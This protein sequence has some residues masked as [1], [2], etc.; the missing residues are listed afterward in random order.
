MNALQAGFASS[1]GNNYEASQMDRF[2]W[3]LATAEQELIRDCVVDRN[4]YRIVGIS[5]LSTWLFATLA[6]TYFFATATDSPFVFTGMG[7]FMGFVILSIDR[8]LIKGI[9]RANK[10]KLTPL[11]F[12][13]LLAIT[14]GTFMAQPA[15]LYLFDKEI[16]LQTSLDNEGRKMMKRKELD[17]LY[18]GQIASVV[19]QQ[20]ML[21]K[22]LND[23]YAEVNAARAGFLAETDGSG[24]SGKVGI[25][26][27]ALAKKKE[28]EKLESDYG[29]LKVVNQP[30]IDSLRGELRAIEDTIRK[31]QAA[32]TQLL[33]NGFLTRIQALQNL[34]K[35]NSALATRYWLVVIILMLI[36]L[37]PVIAKTLLPAGTYD[38]KVRLQEELEKE[39][40]KRNIHRDRELK[41]YFNDAALDA[42][43][44][45][46]DDFFSVNRQRRHDKMEEFGSNWR[47]D[48]VQ[49]FD[50]LWQQMKREI[51]TRWE[52]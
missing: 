36:E 1:P 37:M 16:R 12:R 6:W 30:K 50:G 41:E 47:S 26:T 32:F 2:L 34:L 35:S 40:T 42:D 14:I 8:T 18:S 9:N 52:N 45:A 11:L 46:I 15:I 48:K 27:I 7:I 10:N 13:G 44:A 21:E 4:R 17:R 38:E 31:Q 43:K 20:Q 51:M 24:G 5:V 33:N 25:S 3:W 23:K 29:S 49:S 28:Y 19:S 22:S 39:M